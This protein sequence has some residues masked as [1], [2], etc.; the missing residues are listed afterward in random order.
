VRKVL[1]VIIA[2]VA[3]VG[4]GA[5]GYALGDSNDDPA[6]T[7]GTTV[8][9]TGTTPSGGT[10]GVTGATGSTT[11]DVTAGDPFK[12]L[13][14]TAYTPGGYGTMDTREDLQLLKNLGSTSVTI[15]PTWYVKST[16]AN[17]IKPDKKKTPTDASLGKAISWAKEDGLKVILKPHV[18]VI[19]ETFRGEIQPADRTKWFESYENFIGHYAGLAANNGAELFAVGTELKSIS[20]DTDPWKKV[21]ELVRG[22]FGGQLT[23]AANWD[24]VDQVQF[25]D[26]LDIIGVDAYYPL[27]GEGQ[28]PTEDDLVTAWQTP[29]S[30]LEATSTKWGKPV[31]FTEIG[32]PS[33][34][35]AAAHPYEVRPDDPP[36][37]KAQA[38]AYRAAFQAFADK[39]WFEGMSW[40]SWRADPGPDEKPG[41]DYTPEGKKAE[42]VLAAEQAG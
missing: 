10:T 17:Q 38:V 40:W 7:E 37:Q 27:A 28:V 29:I 31:M 6:T 22:K 24:E 42:G 30:S 15:V 12:G 1:I 8:P 4:V 19:N 13:N 5:I 9:S 18:D 35:G 41:I 3:I 26:A 21:I 11:S 32:Y 16:S 2:M 36:D 25:W 14:L 33:Q 39:T 34:A 23:Y 20:G